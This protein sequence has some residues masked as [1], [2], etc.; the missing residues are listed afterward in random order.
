MLLICEQRCMQSIS[1]TQSFS[2]EASVSLFAVWRQSRLPASVVLVC[3]NIATAIGAEMD[4]SGRHFLH[5]FM[6]GQRPK[7]KPNKWVNGSLWVLM[8]FLIGA[9][10]YLLAHEIIPRR[11]AT[12]LQPPLRAKAFSLPGLLFLMAYA[13]LASAGLAHAASR[14]LADDCHA[15][16]LSRFIDK[17]VSSLQEMNLPE[18]RFICDKYCVATADVRPSRLTVVYSRKTNRVIRLKCE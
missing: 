4:E 14:Q 1:I 12:P 15:S 13:A 11:N 2:N 7:P 9:L 10:I 16:E 17:P 18:A 6:T 5:E 8:A 3:R